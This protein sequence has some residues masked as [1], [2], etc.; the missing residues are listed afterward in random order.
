M[1][2]LVVHP[3]VFAT[4]QDLGRLHHRA[5]GVP[6]GGSFDA[7]SARIANA[8]AGNGSEAATIETTLIGGTYEAKATLWLA[9]AGAPMPALIQRPSGPDFHLTIP[10]TFRL[11]RGSRLVLGPTSVGART[12]LAVHQGWR[13]RLVLGSRSCETPLQPGDELT[14]SPGETFHSRVPAYRLAA[15]EGP[16]VLRV[17]TGPNADQVDPSWLEDGWEYRVD[18]RSNRMGARLEGPKSAVAS[19]PDRRSAPIAPGA[20]Q[21]AGGLPL[22]LGV[23]CGT[24]GGY[25]HVAHVIAADLERLGQARPGDRVRFGRVTTAEAR[26]IHHEASRALRRITAGIRL[27]VYP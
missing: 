18:P 7:R 11:E 10:S 15:R 25:P 1:S 6:V 21:M 22:V 20:I 3:G 14:C 2:L 5:F 19:V 16:I 12:Y 27:M 23:A 8:L 4:V 13:T 9:L 24:M 17:T 26:S